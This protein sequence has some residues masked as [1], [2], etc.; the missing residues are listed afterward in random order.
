MVFFF[1]LLLPM[2]L[3]NLQPLVSSFPPSFWKREQLSWRPKVSMLTFNFKFNKLTE[4]LL[5]EKV[6]LLEFRRH[7]LGVIRKVRQGQP[8]I[9]TYRGQPVMRLEPIR[10]N[11][12][13]ADDPFY[14]IAQL[15][16]ATGQT[17]T[18]EE[19]DQIVYPD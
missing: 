16:T 11:T 6:S 15:A 2:S 18:N 10:A 9:M 17:L 14:L 3:A 12:P 19:I 7:A 8:L 1:M 5:M 13:N 4:Y